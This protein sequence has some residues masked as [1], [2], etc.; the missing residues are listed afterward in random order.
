MAKFNVGDTVIHEILGRGTIERI[1][2]G[3]YRV[4]FDENKVRECLR[5]ANFSDRLHEMPEGVHTYLYKK[6]DKNIYFYDG[7]KLLGKYANEATVDGCHPTDLGF[8]MITENLEKI[9]NKILN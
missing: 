2:D 9:I 3:A 8:M 5:K 1:I 7:H 6:Y 4:R